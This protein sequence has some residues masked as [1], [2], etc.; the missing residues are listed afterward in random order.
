MAVVPTA[1]ELSVVDALRPKPARVSALNRPL[2]GSLPQRRAADRGVDVEAEVG[3]SVVV[4]RG[5]RARRDEA[6]ACKVDVLSS[7][8]EPRNGDDGMDRALEFAGLVIEVDGEA[9]GTGLMVA[10]KGRDGEPA[11]LDPQHRRALIAEAERG[12]GR[13]LRINQHAYRLALSDRA[14]RNPDDRPGKRR[15]GAGEGRAGGNWALEQTDEVDLDGGDARGNG[16]R[17]R[18]RLRGARRIE[19]GER[20]RRRGGGLNFNPGRER[21]GRLVGIENERSGRGGRE[22]QHQQ[23]RQ[24]PWVRVNQP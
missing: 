4:I 23:Q 17:F 16:R 1:P 3:H 2:P 8:L 13:P 14:G 18:P 6:R 24:R 7:N 10:G 12:T 21:C 22:Q 15:F 9:L 5:D 11:G 19:R 20:W